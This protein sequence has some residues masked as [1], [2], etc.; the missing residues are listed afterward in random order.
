VNGNAEQ[1]RKQF[2][3]HEGKRKLVVTAIGNRYSV[4]FEA[5]ARTMSNLMD[6]NIV[7]PTL[8]EWILPSFSTTTTT[9]TTVSCMVMMATMKAYFSYKCRL[10]CGIPR[11]TLEGEKEDWENILARLEKLKQ[12]GKE[13]IAWYQLLRPIISK[14]V[15]A[16]DNP[17]A[18]DNLEFWQKV[19]HYEGG[20][21]GPTWLAGWINAFCVFSE[22]GKWM[23]R[24]IDTK[25][26][27]PSR[28]HSLM[29]DGI[30]YHRIESSDIPAGF[31][32]VDVKL[33]DNGKNFDTILTAGQLCT[34]IC[35]SEDQ[36]L[37]PDGRRDTGRPL[38]AWWLF[39][40]KDEQT[41]QKEYQA[42][43]LW[44]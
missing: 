29:L 12:Y 41:L 34:Q 44:R 4:N 24:P 15:G 11:V 35:D 8:R 19:A 14:F 39:D 28:G 2:V 7:D 6:E 42:R 20:G 38:A 33:D 16:F 21:S 31:A 22:K 27:Q 36:T 30:I 26:P 23:G 25:D 43:H 10:A 37:S 3:S 5:M 18:E 40:K 13:T 32:E 1:L 9:D 17:D